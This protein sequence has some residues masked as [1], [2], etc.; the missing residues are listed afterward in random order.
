MME[1]S[2]VGVFFHGIIAV[3]ML[4]IFYFLVNYD[5]FV[6]AVENE[7]IGTN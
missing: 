5:S 2:E 4:S 3:L 1:V 7:A 6:F